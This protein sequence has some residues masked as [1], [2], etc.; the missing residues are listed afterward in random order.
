MSRRDRFIFHARYLGDRIMKYAQNLGRGR[1]ERVLHDGARFIRGRAKSLY[2]QAIRV[3]FRRIGQP[4]PTIINSEALMVAEWHAYEAS[5]HDVPLVLF[6]AVERPAEFRPDQTLGWR[7]CVSR[8]FEVHLVPGDHCSMLHAPHVQ[9]LAESVV[10][11]LGAARG[12][13]T[14]AGTT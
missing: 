1:P 8:P 5:D 9:I 13:T 3:L 14:D 6:N 11:Y 4:P 12:Q 2:W 10:P 7:A